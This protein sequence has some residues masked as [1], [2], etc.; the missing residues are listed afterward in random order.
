MHARRC[1]ERS[2]TR[3]AIAPGGAVDVDEDD[4]DAVAHGL[5]ELEA[6]PRR[7]EVGGR[8]EDHHRRRVAHGELERGQLDQ[9]VRAGA[10]RTARFFGRSAA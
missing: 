9:A 3:L 4:V 6:A 7:G 1:A 2:A 5:D 10:R 8:E